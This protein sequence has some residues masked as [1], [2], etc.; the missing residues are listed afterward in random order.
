M[1]YFSRPWS[2]KVERLVIPM[3][4]DIRVTYMRVQ[5]PELYMVNVSDPLVP[6]SRMLVLRR[7]RPEFREYDSKSPQSD[8]IGH[9]TVTRNMVQASVAANPEVNIIDYEDGSYAMVEGRGG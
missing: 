3:T 7:S 6:G 8:L 5:M 4:V 9:L 1:I 2:L